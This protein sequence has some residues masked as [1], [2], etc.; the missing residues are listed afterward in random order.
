MPM[1]DRFV[2]VTEAKNKLLDLIRSLKTCQDVVAITRDGIP[3]AI[4]L[5]M[6]Q[7]EGL[8]ETLEILADEKSI[9]SLRR[10]LKQAQS[11]KWKDHETVFGRG[12]V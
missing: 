5:S 3:A 1:V 6:D 7:Y 4:L 2:T 10:S 11:G 8:M 12:D 9:R